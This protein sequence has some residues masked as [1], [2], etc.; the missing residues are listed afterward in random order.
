[1]DSI[2]ISFAVFS[3]LYLV[4]STGRYKLVN[5]DNEDLSNDLYNCLGNQ[6]ID[7]V[8]KQARDAKH[9]MSKHGEQ[10]TYYSAELQTLVNFTLLKFITHDSINGATH[11]EI[12]LQLRNE[13]PESLS[14]EAIC[15][16]LYEIFGERLELKFYHYNTIKHTEESYEYYTDFCVSNIKC[17]LLAELDCGLK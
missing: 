11:F 15:S 17:N 9:F 8:M 13:P 16:I 4:S 12:V 5:R 6:I 2:T 1:M 10:I 14:E 3:E 7:N